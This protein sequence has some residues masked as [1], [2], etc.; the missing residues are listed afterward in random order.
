M[1]KPHK[2]SAIIVAAGESQRMEGV[3]KL[4]APL[5]GEPVIARVLDVFLNCKKVDQIVLV[6][7]LKNIE[8]G[9]RIVALGRWNKIT[10]IALGGKR[11]QDSVA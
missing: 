9:R 1:S 7:G 4:L 6:M 5:G 10:D 11:R 3:D 2:V 8:E